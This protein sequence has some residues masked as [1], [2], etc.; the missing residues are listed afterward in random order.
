MRPVRS[1]TATEKSWPSRAC[2]EY[3][4]LCTVVPTSTA[5]EESAPQMTPSVIGSIARSVM[6]LR[7][8][9]QPLSCQGD[10][11]VRVIVHARRRARGQHGGGLTL[12]DDS[13]A[14][15]AQARSQRVA[16]EHRAV[17]EAARL[18]EVGPPPP[19]ARTRCRGARL[20]KSNSG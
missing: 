10:D 17:D 2:S 16:I 4:V 6:S 11:E 15:D 13:R 5:I 1:N 7:E 9:R 14:R 19:L 18:R 20:R 12:L 8:C 3:A